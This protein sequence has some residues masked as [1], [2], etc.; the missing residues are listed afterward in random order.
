MSAYLVSEKHIGLIAA[1]AHKHELTQY[2]P[3][4]KTGLY[5]IEDIAECL[6]QA[7][8]DSVD[9]R[10]PNQYIEDNVEAKIYI[11][12][13]I[14]QAKAINP[15]VFP[16][17]YIAKQLDCLEYQSCEPDNWYQSNAFKIMTNIR[18]ELVKKLSDYENASWGM[19]Y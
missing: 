12:N 2:G 9:H 11:K 19:E 3:C 8:I 18:A 6:A 10:Y 17:G 7:N 1:Y 4:S 16:S 5:R 15:D 14:D 13:A